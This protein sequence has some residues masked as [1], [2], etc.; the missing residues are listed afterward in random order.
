MSA[1]IMDLAFGK[2]TVRYISIDIKRDYDHHVES[3]ELPPR[4]A[5]GYI[6]MVQALENRGKHAEYSRK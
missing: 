2:S 4:N 6:M 3:K 5:I 1:E